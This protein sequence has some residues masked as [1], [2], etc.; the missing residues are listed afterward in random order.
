MAEEQN[1]PGMV[2]YNIKQANEKVRNQFQE[3]LKK[4]IGDGALRLD[5]S[6]RHPERIREYLDGMYKIN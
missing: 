5:D 3:R 4:E 6:D 1:F 2:Q